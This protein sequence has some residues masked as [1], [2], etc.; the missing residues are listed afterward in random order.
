M[1][2]SSS[3]YPEI[4]LE[5]LFLPYGQSRFVSASD[6][7]RVFHRPCE[8]RTDTCLWLCL[9]CTDCFIIMALQFLPRLQ[10]LGVV[11]CNVLPSVHAQSGLLVRLLLDPR[12]RA[13]YSSIHLR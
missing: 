5:H 6:I 12:V 3:L 10:K 7:H 2:R 11:M 8:S 1:R 4:E 9:P 13:R